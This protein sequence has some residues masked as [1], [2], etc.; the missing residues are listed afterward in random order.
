MSK[1][2]FELDPRLARDCFAVGRFKLCRLLLMNNAAV[3]WFILVP[4]TDVTEICDLNLL[5]QAIL[6]DEINTVSHY[7]QELDGVQKL[8]VAAIGNI[9]RQLHIHIV[10]R[11]PGDFVWPGVVWGVDT[12]ERYAEAQVDRIRRQVADGLGE[13]FKPI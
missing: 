5:A 8:N 4:E 1:K 9:V 12:S 13:D 11:H 2:H 7:V 3:P 10:G 6:Y